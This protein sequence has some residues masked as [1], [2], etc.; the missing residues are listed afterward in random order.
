LID[1]TSAQGCA[2]TMNGDVMTSL[3]G[4]YEYCVDTENDPS[5]SNCS[6]MSEI[7]ETYDVQGDTIIDDE[8]GQMTRIPT[9]QD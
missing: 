3:A 4:R 8:G 2:D 5:E 6:D 9:Y 1:Q 7:V